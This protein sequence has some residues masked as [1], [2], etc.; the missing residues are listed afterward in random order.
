LRWKEAARPAIG[1]AVAAKMEDVNFR[2]KEAQT[3]RE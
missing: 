3:D 1:E 2:E